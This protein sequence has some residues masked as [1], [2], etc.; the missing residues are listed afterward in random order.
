LKFI[1]ILINTIMNNWKV[2]DKAIRKERICEIVHIDLTTEPASLTVR[3]LDN[4]TEV[5]T[6]FNRIKKV[7]KPKKKNNKRKK[8]KI[9]K[10]YEKRGKH[11]RRYYS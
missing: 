6:E 7:P 9:K 1:I 5:G 3:M 11:H 10:K 4:N 2:G 8:K